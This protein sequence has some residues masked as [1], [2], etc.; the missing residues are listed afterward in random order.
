MSSYRDVLCA[1]MLSASVDEATLGLPGARIPTENQ[2]RGKPA[3]AR[4]FDMGSSGAIP[5]RISR[6]EPRLLGRTSLARFRFQV[7]SCIALL[8]RHSQ[9]GAHASRLLPA[10]DDFRCAV[11]APWHL[12]PDDGPPRVW[13]AD[14]VRGPPVQPRPSASGVQLP[15]DHAFQTKKVTVSDSPAHGGLLCRGLGPAGVFCDKLGETV[16]ATCRKRTLAGR[17]GEGEW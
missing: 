16:T 12:A 2:K 4:A 9:N 8:R 3:V 11:H 13:T 10:K 7:A 15:P 14:L 5:K 17:A 6:M 1:P